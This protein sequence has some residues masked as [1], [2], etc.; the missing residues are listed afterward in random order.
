[1]FF[2]M[3][4]IFCMEVFLYSAVWILIA[5][6]FSRPQRVNVLD[7]WTVNKLSVSNNLTYW[8]WVTNIGVGTL[9]I[10]GSDISLSPG[11][12]Q[13]II[14]TNAVILLIETLETNFS[15]I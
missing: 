14:W 1:M 12:R 5:R 8:G 13:A 9:T 2:A 3:D 15:E 10:I 6:C 7:I 11:R 4:I